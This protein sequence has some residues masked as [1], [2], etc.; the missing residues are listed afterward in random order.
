MHPQTLTTSIGELRFTDSE[1]AGAWVD[2]WSG[3]KSRYSGTPGVWRGPEE[4]ALTEEVKDEVMDLQVK[5]PGVIP[6]SESDEFA[7]QEGPEIPLAMSSLTLWKIA[8]HD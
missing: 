6:E 2:F 1:V 7:E 3:P 8:T 5:H 4:L